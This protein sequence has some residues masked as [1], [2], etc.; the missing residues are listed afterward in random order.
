MGKA[1]CIERVASKEVD[2]FTFHAITDLAVNTPDFELKINPRVA[3]GEVPNSSWFAVVEGC[4]RFSTRAAGSFFPVRSRR[5]IRA[6]GSPNNPNTCS[7]GLKPG[8]RY[9]SERCLFI[10]LKE[11]Q[12]LIDLSSPYLFILQY[13]IAHTLAVFTHSSPR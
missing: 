12:F 3:A 11:C 5:T 2:L 6:L 13:H 10:T 8:N 7:R 9:A 4:G 1:F